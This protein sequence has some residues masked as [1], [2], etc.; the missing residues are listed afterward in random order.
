MELLNFG[1]QMVARNALTA[2]VMLEICCLGARYF[3]MGLD[4]GMNDSF[5]MAIAHAVIFTLI[6]AAGMHFGGMTANFFGWVYIIAAVFVGNTIGS[7]AQWWTPLSQV[8]RPK[9]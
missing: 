8:V 9:K 1:L 3:S 5:K 2:Y 7:V 6:S 4:G